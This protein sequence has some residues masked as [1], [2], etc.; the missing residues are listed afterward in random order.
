MVLHPSWT[1]S[2]GH[3]HDPPYI[4][5]GF[6]IIMLPTCLVKPAFHESPQGRNVVGADKR[7]HQIRMTDRNAEEGPVAI[8]SQTMAAIIFPHGQAQNI[9]PGCGRPK[10]AQDLPD[11]FAG[12]R[13]RDINRLVQSQELT[14][15]RQAI[16]P[17]VPNIFCQ[18]PEGRAI[19]RAAKVDRQFGSGKYCHVTPSGPSN[20]WINMMDNSNYRS[21][22]VLNYGYP[23]GH[24]REKHSPCEINQFHEL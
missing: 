11:A 6:I 14:V 8:A 7:F 15:K 1:L 12:R 22:P 19:V 9:I 23:Y 5:S 13:S 4:V 20:N 24:K 17:F 2:I 16:G 3:P 10:E 18:R 21:N